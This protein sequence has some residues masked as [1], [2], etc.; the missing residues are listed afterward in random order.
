MFVELVEGKMLLGDT[1]ITEYKAQETNGVIKTFRASAT[2]TVRRASAKTTYAL[3]DPNLRIRITRV[4]DSGFLI[5]SSDSDSDSD[6][7]SGSE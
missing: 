4:P 3:S 1:V 5:V 7:D 2:T 6:S